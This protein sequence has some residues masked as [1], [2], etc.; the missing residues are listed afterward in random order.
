[1]ETSQPYRAFELLSFAASLS[2]LTPKN[3]P[4]LFYFW[5]WDACE[6]NAV[7]YAAS[8]STPVKYDIGS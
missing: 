3:P 7:S 8:V 2:W 1:M 4:F 6:L 5:P